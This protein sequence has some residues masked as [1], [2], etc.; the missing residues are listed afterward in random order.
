MG[1]KIG[2]DSVEWSALSLLISHGISREKGE[3]MGAAHSPITLE[4]AAAAAFCHLL[5]STKV[6]EDHRGNQ[7]LKET[8]ACAG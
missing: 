7:I 3:N 1:Q 6:Y 2:R 4:S 5:R 8:C